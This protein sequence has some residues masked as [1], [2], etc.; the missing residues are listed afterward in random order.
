VL[1]VAA[2]AAAR[3]LIE[4]IADFVARGG[5]VDWGIAIGSPERADELVAG[6]RGEPAT[7]SESAPPLPAG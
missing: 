5:S 7:A 2:G 1:V 4:R 6:V 3:P